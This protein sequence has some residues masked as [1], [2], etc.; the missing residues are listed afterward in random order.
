M[1]VL[2]RFVLS[3]AVDYVV[4]AGMVV[5]LQFSATN[6]DSGM[7]SSQV[8]MPTPTPGVADEGHRCVTVGIVDDSLAEPTESFTVILDST[9]LDSTFLDSTFPTMSVNVAEVNIID[10]DCESIAYL[11]IY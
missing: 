7:Y 3:P 4:P 10:N 6:G 9:F 8:L 2:T 11:D 1:F 5:T